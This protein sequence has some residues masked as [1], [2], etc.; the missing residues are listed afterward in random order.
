MALTIPVQ[1]GIGRRF[2]ISGWKS[3]KHGSPTMDVL[4]ILGTSCAFFFSVTAMLVSIFFPPHSRPSTIFD[5]ST[6]LITFVTL[7][8]YLENNA[9]GKTSKAL[10]RLMSLAPSMATIYADPIAAEKA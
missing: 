8:R 2:Y 7:G 3:I 6:M 10:S 4:V 1:F 5:T 9:K